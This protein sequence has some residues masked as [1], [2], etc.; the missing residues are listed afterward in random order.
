MFRI[1]TADTVAVKPAPTAAGTEAWFRK[2]D[3]VGTLGTVLTADWANIIQGELSNLLTVASPAI[4]PDKTDHTQ[5]EDALKAWPEIGGLLSHLTDTGATSNTLHPRVIMA[6]IGNSR[7]TGNASACVATNGATVEGAASAAMASKDCNVK[8]AQGVVIACEEVKIGDVGSGEQTAALACLSTLTDAVKNRGTACAL[9]ACRG[10][11]GTN[12]L[13]G[14]G[15]VG[16]ALIACADGDHDVSTTTVGCALIACKSAEF[17]GA[18][19]AS[20]IIASGHNAGGTVTDRPDINAADYSAVIGVDGHVK[21]TADNCVVLASSIG[22]TERV[23]SDANA[24]ILH[25]GTNVSIKMLSAS[26]RI[27]CNEF[28]C[29]DNLAMDGGEGTPTFGTMPTGGAEAQSEWLEI[30]VDGNTRYIPLWAPA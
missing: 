11:S 5:I 1:D 15:A 3:G 24:V 23:V 22:A 16:C 14:A 2:N 9:V 8:T 21:V 18:A 19:V 27:E 25:D 12:I 28:R 4:T 17:T 10:G 6:A 30:S 29:D 26:G 13:V 7:S 20:A